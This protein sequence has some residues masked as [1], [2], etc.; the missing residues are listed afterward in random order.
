MHAHH[1]GKLTDQTTLII[2]P[3]VDSCLTND[4]VIGHDREDEPLVSHDIAPIRA[5]V[6]EVCF[7][8]V[9]ENWR[10]AM[11]IFFG[12]APSHI[13]VDDPAGHFGRLDSYLTT[14]G[15]REIKSRLAEASERAV[16][17]LAAEARGDHAEAKRLWRI[18]FGDEFP[19]G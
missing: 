17:A 15:L 12:Y 16:R 2:I 8:P 3:E 14:S 13:A 18:E 11:K 5:D 6:R 9:V 7:N 10:Q 19:I 1:H 4:L